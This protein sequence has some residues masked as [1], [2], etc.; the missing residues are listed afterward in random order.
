MGFFPIEINRITKVFAGF[1]ALDSLSFRLEQ[2]ETL[3]LLGPNGAGKSTM[4][5]LILGLQK[6]DSG[7]IKIFGDSPG[8]NAARA[9][10]GVTPQDLD[11]PQTLKTEEIL[12]LVSSAFAKKGSPDFIER[13]ELQKILSRKACDLSGGQKRRLGLACALISEPKILILDEPTTG[14]DSESRQWLWKIIREV[15]ASGTSVLLTSHYMDEVEALAHRILLIENGR[16]SFTGTVNEIKSRYDVQRV[17]FVCDV[18]MSA[19]KADHQQLIQ[20]LAKGSLE[21]KALNWQFW[22]QNSDQAIKDLCAHQFPFRLLSVQAISLD[23]A[24]MKV[25]DLK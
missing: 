17:S 18:E 7:E 11:F 9:T 8:S 4:I 6:I 13:F 15:N 5:K 21:Q 19:L 14:L 24:L 2:G 20:T 23:E 1:R 10:I 16:E 12:S 3:A 25:R 22:T